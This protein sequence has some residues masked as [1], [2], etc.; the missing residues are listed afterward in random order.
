MGVLFFMACITMSEK[1]WFKRVNNPSKHVKKMRKI[2]LVK[3]LRLKLWLEQ[4]LAYTGGPQDR[5]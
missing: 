5:V 3:V 2:L 1:M 4:K